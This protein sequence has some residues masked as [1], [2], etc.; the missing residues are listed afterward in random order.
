MPCNEDKDGVGM[1]PLRWH[2][3]KDFLSCL[4]TLNFSLQNIYEHF[5]HQVAS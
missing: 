2:Q 5:I 3:E 1:K 4:I